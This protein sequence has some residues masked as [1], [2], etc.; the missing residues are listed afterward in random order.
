M[1]RRI[2]FVSLDTVQFFHVAIYNLLLL[3]TLMAPHSPQFRESPFMDAITPQDRF[4]RQQEAILS[5]AHDG[6]GPAQIT[7]FLL[8]LSAFR[9]GLSVTFLRS[10]PLGSC[11]P[12]FGKDGS[13]AELFRVS[14]GKREVIFNRTA[15]NLLSPAASI[16]SR[17]KAATKLALMRAGVRGPAGL[18]V[19][20]G[21]TATAKGF[22]DHHKGK[23]FVV[24]P[25]NGTLAR[26][27][28]V[29][30][31]A[32]QAVE[33]IRTTDEDRMMLEEFIVGPEL[34]VNVVGDE[35][36]GAY[37][38]HAAFVIGDG[39]HSIEE[40]TELKNP[41]TKE[42]RPFDIGI[43]LTDE[44]LAYLKKQGLSPSFV[45]DMGQKVVLSHHKN[46]SHG[47]EF[48]VASDMLNDSLKKVCVMAAK[49]IGLSVAGMD[50]VVSD[51]PETR[52]SYILELNDRPILTTHFY[53][54]IGNSEGMRVFDAIID[55]HFPKTKGKALFSDATFD[56]HAI[57]SAMLATSAEQMALPVLDA[58]YQHFRVNFR[59]E[60]VL[61]AVARTC[62]NAGAYLISAPDLGG[63]THL[64]DILLSRRTRMYLADDRE[65]LRKLA[66]ELE[67]QIQWVDAADTQGSFAKDARD[68]MARRNQLMIA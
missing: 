14:D 6:A 48:E 28:K 21:D 67:A 18:A 17:D 5:K 12:G 51:D 55:H 49:A 32:E 16:L 45:P 60:Q 7:S 35:V 2:K 22:V 38:R 20:A 39:S 46:L 25:V 29:A 52:G 11:M 24:K 3:L 47:A 64:L 65:L 34:R 61:K 36:V 23:L 59:S 4:L 10:A 26:G 9:R 50:V 31:T 54:G 42:R 56:Y 37:I 58:D 57:S 19:K 43:V 62:R 33:E 40:L 68:M 63:D 27:V 41:K 44:K 53:P 1:S 13:G 30:L 15:T 66:P 8:A